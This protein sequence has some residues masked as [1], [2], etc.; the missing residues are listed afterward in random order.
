MSDSLRDELD[1]FVTDHGYDGRSEL[2]R[3]ACQSLLEE[4]QSIDF[5][6]RDVIGTVT[7]VFGYDEQE[8][9]RQMMEIR[10][11]FETEIRSNSHNCLTNNAGC[12]ETFVLEAKSE[13][14]SK[15]VETVRA[16]D[17]SVCVRSI[18]IPVDTMN[19]TEENRK[20]T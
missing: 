12:V 6:G 10:H 13:T 2:I 20:S 4:S 14:V 8:I 5:E 1:Q 15:F 16:V 19:S 18:T 17:E 3:E 7:A 9:E 11:A